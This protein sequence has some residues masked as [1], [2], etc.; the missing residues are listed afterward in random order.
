MYEI[1]KK[2]VLDKIR[3]IENSLSKLKTL[4]RL[5]LDEFISDFRYFDSAKYN[6]QTAIEAMIDIGN[7]VIS[8]RG[9]GIPKTYADTFEILYKSGIIAKNDA[10]IYKLMA[11]FRNRIV[12]FYDEVDDKE[13]YGI[14]QNNLGDFDSFIQQISK[15]L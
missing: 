3:V 5:P 4:S 11:K 10:D 9:L 2:R 14:L 7:H 8:R 13:V 12:H 15:L 1:D 6:L